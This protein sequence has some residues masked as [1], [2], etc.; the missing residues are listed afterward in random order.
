MTTIA[1]RDG[2]LAADTRM[3]Y[4]MSAIHYPNMKLFEAGGYAI[5]LC[6]DLRFSPVL[7]DWAE[8]G[9]DPKAVH[10]K[11]WDD[12]FDVLVMNAQ[13]ELFTA[14]AHALVPAP[15]CEF[16]AVGSGRMAALGAMACGASAAEAIQIASEF[17]V[18]T[19]LPVQQISAA[20]LQQA[21]Q[22]RSAAHGLL[23]ATQ[24]YP[25]TID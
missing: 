24:V 5:G 4:G 2:I 6:G 10:D 21:L 7:R 3:S 19:G 9:F 11:I 13:G 12:E 25:K 23:E 16:Y 20:D 1:F 14:L 17:D 22:D 8:A 18:G 15:P